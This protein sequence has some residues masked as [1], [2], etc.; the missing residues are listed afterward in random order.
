MKTVFLDE[1]GY[2]GPD[3]F[4]L[5]QPVFV[6]ATHDF[7]EEE[8]SAFRERFFGKIQAEE[9]KHQVLSRRSSQQGMLL[10]FFRHIGPTASKR[11]K[12]YAVHKRYALTMKLIDY[13]VETSMHK[14]GLN[15]YRSGG[16]VAMTN[17]VYAVLSG[18]APR[19]LE[20]ILRSF[21]AL[22]RRRGATE[23]RQ[24][25]STLRP[26]QGE[27]VVEDLIGTLRG[28]AFDVGPHVLLTLPE[29]ALDLPLTLALV[30]LDAWRKQTTGL[31][32]LAYD[33]SNNWAKQRWMW[34]ALTDPRAPR[35][36]VGYAG[37]HATYPIELAESVPASSAASAAIQIADLLA[38][39]L[40]RW[41]TSQVVQKREDAY[42]RSLGEVFANVEAEWN[43]PTRK[44]S[45]EDLGLT[46]DD[47]DDPL[48]YLA[49]RLSAARGKRQP[50]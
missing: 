37:R 44:F 27:E 12:F 47:A 19:R 28:A 11:A 42:G 40:C 41:L 14:H 5:D 3:L 38:G 49:E 23:C 43:W 9:L 7:S 2:T 25:L 21:Q 36:T 34:D 18:R 48:E 45:P 13:V 30:C 50:E 46:G 4:G 20:Q 10:D 35:A 29:D 24:F 31:L 17:V 16:L 6:V 1:C 32:R 39:G 22:A 26:Q 33:Q 15:L 8:S